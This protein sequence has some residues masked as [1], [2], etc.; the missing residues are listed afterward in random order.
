MI[1]RCESL[2]AGFHTNQFD[3]FV[4]QKSRK[5]ANRIASTTY[6]CHDSIGQFVVLLQELRPRFLADHALKVADH[7]G[8]GMRSDDRT[9]GIEKVLGILQILFKRAVDGILQSARSTGDRHH[10]A[11]ENLHFRNIGVFSEWK[12]KDVRPVTHQQLPQ[13]FHIPSY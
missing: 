6:T 5:D 8:K 13:S 2:P 7:A 3:I 12:L 4:F 9:N 11:A 1:W 10:S